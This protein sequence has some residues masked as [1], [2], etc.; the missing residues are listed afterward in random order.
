MR[1]TYVTVCVDYLDYL[2]VA[3]QHNRGQFDD[4]V[5]VTA[6]HDVAT[7]RFCV[8]NQIGLQ[9]TDVFYRGGAT[10]NKGAGLNEGL[11]LAYAR[12]QSKGES[13]DWV[14]I[15]D[16][17]TFVPHDFRA[18]LVAA[19][20]N[21]ELLYGARRT[22]LPT[23]GHYQIM[24]GEQDGWSQLKTPDG[25]AFG[26]LQLFHWDNPLFQRLP[27]GA[28]YPQTID[29]RDCDWMFMRALGG[30]LADEYTR[31]VGN[32]AKLPFHVFNLGPDGVNHFGRRS[33]EFAPP[34]ATVPIPDVFS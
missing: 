12:T 2:A 1:I 26:W 34:L 33:V 14:A 7:Q 10:F 18:Q 27:W 25:H 9:V 13:L 30:D 5:V 19:N 20:L 22:L 11:Q 6:P 32:V 15:M 16:A 4:M 8:E 3:Y 21:R 24:Q 31:S 29:C 28:W 23:W 17:D